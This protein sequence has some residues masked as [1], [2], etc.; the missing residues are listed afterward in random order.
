MASQGYTKQQR[1]I[2]ILSLNPDTSATPTTLRKLNV[3][4]LIASTNPAPRC[5]NKLGNQRQDTCHICMMHKQSQFVVHANQN[6][7]CPHPSCCRYV[8]HLETA[9][10]PME[11]H[12]NVKLPPLWNFEKRFCDGF[13]AIRSTSCAGHLATCQT[14]KISKANGKTGYH[15]LRTINSL[16]CIGISSS[17]L[18]TS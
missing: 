7:R 1:K 16:D 3:W 10:L 6:R 9:A 11:H 13:V 8:V 17:I 5:A 12:V 15:A 2:N 4:V 18:E 14:H